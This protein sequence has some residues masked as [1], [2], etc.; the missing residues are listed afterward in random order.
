MSEKKYPTKAG[1]IVRHINTGHI[2]TVTEFLGANE[3]ALYKTL[4]EA[5]AEN[6]SVPREQICIIWDVP[7]ELNPTN[8]SKTGAARLW[9]VEL[10]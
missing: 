2:F 5:R 3:T 10:V 9:E 4:E 6:L 7:E 8:P 1:D